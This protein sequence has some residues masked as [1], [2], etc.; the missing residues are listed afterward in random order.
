MKIGKRIHIPIDADMEKSK[1]NAFRIAND[2]NS[3]EII[4]EENG[5]KYKDVWRVGKTTNSQIIIETDNSSQDNAIVVRNNL[6]VLMMYKFS[7]IKTLHGYHFIGSYQ[8][9]PAQWIILNCRILNSGIR[10]DNYQ[11]Y[12]DQLKQFDLNLMEAPKLRT[13]EIY[14]AWLRSGLIQVEIGDIDILYTKISILSGMSTL[15]ISKKIEN[16]KYELV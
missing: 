16:D 12:I 15:R 6:Q 13:S 4:Y 3:K 9:N 11:A 1:M 8:H 7:M 5:K 10:S 2:M 14:K